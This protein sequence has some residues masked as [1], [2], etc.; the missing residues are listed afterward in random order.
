[1]TNWKDS[2]QKGRP[3]PKEDVPKIMIYALLRYINGEG[4]V[5]ANAT[6]EEKL[7]FIKERLQE[8]I[9]LL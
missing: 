8:T 6:A 1:M 3:T 2:I 4:G 5:G 7:E 9:E